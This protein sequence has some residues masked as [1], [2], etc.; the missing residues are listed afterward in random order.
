[1][2]VKLQQSVDFVDYGILP[3]GECQQ[4]NNVAGR[5]G[6]LNGKHVI[7]MLY[8]IFLPILTKL[9]CFEETTNWS[10]DEDSKFVAEGSVNSDEPRNRN[11]EAV[12]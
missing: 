2:F 8:L 10:C 6:N 3:S 12:L 11:E 7:I 9:R 4:S 1:M 5:I